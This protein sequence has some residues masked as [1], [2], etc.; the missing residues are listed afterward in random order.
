M[1]VLT[2]Q[3]VIAVLVLAGMLV[4]SAIHSQTQDAASKRKILDRVAPIYPTLHNLTLRGVVRID[5]LVAPDGHVKTVEIKGGHPLLAQ[6]AEDAV[7]RWKW[8]PTPR[9]SHESVEVKFAPY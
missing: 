8:E 6:A 7:R 5:A 9:E 1:K 2:R 4:L 3:C